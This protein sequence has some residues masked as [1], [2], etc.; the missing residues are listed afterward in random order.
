[1]CIENLFVRINRVWTKIGRWYTLEEMNISCLK[2]CQHNRLLPETVFGASKAL[3]WNRNCRKDFFVR[4]YY[5]QLVYLLIKCMSGLFL[6]QSKKWFLTE[7][8][9][10]KSLH[11]GRKLKWRP[12]CEWMK[13][14]KQWRQIVPLSKAVFVYI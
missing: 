14:P 11:F 1:M 5:D 12:L 7:F 13:K 8:V 3:F 10:S 2:F 4:G 6:R 9:T